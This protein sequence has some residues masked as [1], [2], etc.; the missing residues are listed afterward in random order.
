MMILSAL[1]V[2][3]DAVLCAGIGQHISG[4]F[5]GIG[6][7]FILR[8]I[9]AAGGNAAVLTCFHHCRNHHGRCAEYD[10]AAA[11]LGKIF[12]EFLHEGLHAGN[13]LIHLPVAGDNSLAILSV[14]IMCSLIIMIR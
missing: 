5:A 10:V 13:Q 4:D 1:R 12:L 6:A 7:L 14:H 8:D 2:T 11:G 3:D 9:L